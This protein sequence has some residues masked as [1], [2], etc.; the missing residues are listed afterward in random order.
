MDI[1]L[2]LLQT[3]KIEVAKLSNGTMYSAYAMSSSVVVISDSQG[4]LEGL[5]S[6][7]RDTLH[8]GLTNE[9]AN[10]A[11]SV[12]V[13]DKKEL[14]NS[15]KDTFSYAGISHI[16]AVSGLH[17]GFLVLVITFILN[18]CRVGRRSRFLITS[19]LLLG[20]CTLCGFSASVLRA[21]FMTIVLLLS[22]VV[23]KEYD[24]LNSL[25]LAGI[26]VLL[27]SPID[28]FSLGFQLSFMCV[29]MIITLADKLGKWL[30][31]CN[32]PDE[33]AMAISISVCTTI[34]SSVILANSL[35]EISLISVISNLIV[36]PLFSLAYP[37]LFVFSIIA[38]IVP[39]FDILLILPEIILHF[40]K[41]VA[42]IFAGF[43]FAHF[44]V[45]NLGWMLVLLFITVSFIVKFFMGRKS[46]K[47]IICGVLSILCIICVIIGSIPA[48]FEKFTLYTNYQ[49]LSNS[50]VITTGSNKKI[51]VGIDKYSTQN[52]LT[53]LKINKIDLLVLP[54]FQINRMDNYL[55]FLKTIEVKK[56]LIPTNSLFLDAVFEE[57]KSF[58]EVEIGDSYNCEVVVNFVKSDDVV[59]GT[60]LDI[61]SKKLLFTNGITKLKLNKI[62]ELD[63][64]YDYVVTNESKYDFKEFGIEYG[65]II[66]SNDLNFESNSLISLKNK[67]LYVLEL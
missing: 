35:Y 26:V 42:S 17:V 45:F 16:L 20:Y 56:I 43:E 30:I 48:K 21:S 25:G 12:L 38:M 11:Y 7:L 40:I 10:I 57:L 37:L 27:I 31:N 49:Y 13:G 34:G 6:S 44:R 62:G 32:F 55:D 53:E 5:R 19:L 58:S 52:L 3:D 2:N 15:V 24:G 33:I 46:T 59:C 22:G 66:C 47:T 4:L 50:A 61:N 18:L 51:L 36:I 63:D 65:T 54:D 67:S 64:A 23:G 28:L 60:E 29:F 41:F 1:R 39:I 14:D 8:D 9:N